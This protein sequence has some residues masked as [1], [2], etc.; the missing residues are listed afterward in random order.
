MIK[1]DG[2]SCGHCFYYLRLS[3][4]LGVMSITDSGEIMFFI[5]YSIVSYALYMMHHYDII[6]HACDETLQ[7]II[8]LCLIHMHSSHDGATRY[9]K[10]STHHASRGVVYLHHT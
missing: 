10:H 4:M 1:H 3:P 8:R 9:P 5:H 6:G 2:E 7:S